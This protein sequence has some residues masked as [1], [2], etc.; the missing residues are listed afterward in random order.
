MSTDVEELTR[1]AP[2]LEILSTGRR[3]PST[4]S[5]GSCGNDRDS[6]EDDGS[7]EDKKRQIVLR[8]EHRKRTRRKNLCETHIGVALNKRPSMMSTS[9]DSFYRW[10]DAARTR[11]GTALHK[12]T[13]GGAFTYLVTER[14]RICNEPHVGLLNYRLM[15]TAYNYGDQ[16]F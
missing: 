6:K 13:A 5:R 10:L 8:R 16:I 15:R 11:S 1:S 7:A 3:R 14:D 12:R 2:G 4:I 9:K